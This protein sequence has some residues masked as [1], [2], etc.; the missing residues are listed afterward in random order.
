MWLGWAEA[1]VGLRLDA[2]THASLCIRLNPYDHRI[3]NS[4]LA[5]AMVSLCESDFTEASRWAELAIQARP[6]TPVGRIVMIACCGW[7]GNVR[8][9]A[10]ELAA[11]NKFAP[12]F[13]PSVLRGE[14]SVFKRP[15]DITH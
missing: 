8:R 15:E 3:T 12:D 6:A 5:L 4:Y 7:T 11:L 14:S 10:H 2:K 9:A 1:C 13:V